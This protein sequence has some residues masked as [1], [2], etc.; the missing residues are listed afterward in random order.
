MNVFRRGQK[1]KH[2]E[3]SERESM[4]SGSA[5]LI[6]AER[7]AMEG[8]GRC[9]WPCWPTDPS[10]LSVSASSMRFSPVAA[11]DVRPCRRSTVFF[12]FFNE[13]LLRFNRLYAEFFFLS[14][15]VLS[16]FSSDVAGFGRVC[17]CFYTRALLGFYRVFP[18]FFCYI[19]VHCRGFRGFVHFFLDFMGF[20]R[21]NLFQPRFTSKISIMLFIVGT[22]L[23]HTIVYQFREILI[24]IFKYSTVQKFQFYGEKL[25]FFTSIEFLILPF[26]SI[27]TS[28]ERNLFFPLIGICN[29][30]MNTK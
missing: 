26:P 14:Y 18:V 10:L 6:W 8:V 17:S 9:G 28:K 13:D 29:Y 23:Y 5:L 16:F 3:G 7:M 20:I 15:W 22:S 24:R 25:T 1:S 4:R 30:F 2:H 19:Y 11:C 27:K 12:S 21:L